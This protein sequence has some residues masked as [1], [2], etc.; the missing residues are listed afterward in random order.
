MWTSVC[1]SGARRCTTS[2]CAALVALAL[3]LALAVCAEQPVAVATSDQLSTSKSKSRLLLNE[4][5]AVADVSDTLATDAGMKFTFPDVQ[6]L[7]VL[8]DKD[9]VKKRAKRVAKTRKLGARLKKM[10]A[11]AG[12]AADVSCGSQMIGR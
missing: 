8:Y 9:Y 7:F 3:S 5:V 11:A 10:I 6:K 12:D 2:V 1:S 4:N